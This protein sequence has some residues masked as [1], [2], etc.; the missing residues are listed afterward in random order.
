MV[1]PDNLYV[2]C[3]LCPV[4]E[5]LG[6]LLGLFCHEVLDFF[7]EPGVFF[8][9][10]VDGA[11]KVRCIVEEGPCCGNSALQLEYKL[12]CGFTRYGLYA[13]YAC[14]HSPFGHYFEEADIARGAF[15]GASAKLG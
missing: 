1:E 3:G 9:Q 5:L 8:Y 11:G 7:L 14:C 13:A 10:F 2:S 6:Q 12:F 15:V 4:Y